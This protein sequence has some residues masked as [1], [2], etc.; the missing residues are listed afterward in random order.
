MTT[1]PFTLEKPVWTEADFEQMGWHDVHI[2][3]VAF[4]PEIFELWL[5]IDYIF[6]WVD[7]KGAETHYS[8]WVAPVTLVFTNVHTLRFD[9]ESHDGDLSL[10]GIGRSE[11]CAARNAEFLTKKTEWLWLLDCN[12]GE[13]AFR[14]VGFSQFTRRPPV[15]LQAQQLTLEERGGISF[16]TDYAA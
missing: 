9:L 15:L 1:Q 4:R 10:Q 3:A 16:V 14:S 6:S 13:I 11:P 8:F 7:P 2:H 5:D 12:E